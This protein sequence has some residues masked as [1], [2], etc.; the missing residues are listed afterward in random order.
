M[1]S[2]KSRQTGFTIPELLTAVILSGFFASLILYFGFSYWRY[3]SL[4]EA[5]TDTLVTRLDANDYLRDKLGTT[6][7]LIN[8]NSLADTHAMNTDPVLGSSYWIP[9]HSVPGTTL[10]T[11]SGTAPLMYFKRLATN[12]SGAYIMNGANPYENE[13]ILY[14]NRATKQLLVRT[15]ANP[16]ATGNILKTSCP[17]AS[18]TTSCPADKVI[19]D[20]LVSIDRKYFSRFDATIDFTATNDGINPC[21]GGSEGQ[22]GGTYTGCT[23]YDFQ[24]VEVVELTLHIAEKTFLQQ[25]NSTQ[26][27]T[28]IRVALRNI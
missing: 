17:P 10:A 3:S 6:S 13:Y 24:A 18:A 2:L 9:M 26:N 19:V 7:G 4:L 22:Y 14:I 21:S 16:A 23:G 28:V 25:A 11:G 12:S 8:Q 20:N 15:L 1:I 5:D 27:D